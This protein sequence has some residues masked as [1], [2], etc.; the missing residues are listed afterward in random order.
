MRHHLEEQLK[1]KEELKALLEKQITSL[2]EDMDGL[3][4]SHQQEIKNLTVKHQQEV[5]V[6]N[7]F[8][9]TFIYRNLTFNFPELVDI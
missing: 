4:L 7:W 3:K 5:G 6:T 8:D 2:K 9:F 1:E